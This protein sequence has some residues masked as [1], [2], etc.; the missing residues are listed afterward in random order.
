[1]IAV[2]LGCTL[3]REAFS[4]ELFVAGGLI[5]VA[6]ALIVRGGVQPGA[7]KALQTDTKI[8][9]ATVPE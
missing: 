7:K 5:I 2:L 1:L 6:V 4:H 3:G 9:T 8:P